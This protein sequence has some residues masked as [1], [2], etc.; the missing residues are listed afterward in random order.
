MTYPVPYLI[1]VALL[2][3]CALIVAAPSASGRTRLLSTVVAVASFFLFFAFRGFIMSDWIVYYPYFVHCSWSDIYTYTIGSV[4]AFEPGYTILNL[5]CR[6]VFD[7]YFFFQFVVCLIDTVLLLRFLRQR[8][9]NIPLALTLFVV[10]SGLSII[11]NL[12]RNF[13]AILLFLNAL[14]YLEERRPLPYFLMC[15]LAATFH[16]TALVYMPLYFILHRSFSKWIYLGVFIACNV[17]FLGKIS[18][19]MALVSYS[20]LDEQMSEKVRVYT[21]LFSNASVLSIGY[22][23]RLATGLLVFCYYDRLREINPRNSVIINALLLYFMAF[24]LLSE[25]ETL[26]QRSGYLFVFSYWVIWIDLMKCFAITN[27]RK[28]FVSFVMF[29]CLL[30]TWSMTQLPDMQYDNV[31]TGMKSYQERLVIHN[32]TTND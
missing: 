1:L 10:F 22:L 18:L 28:L 25:F 20:G 14:P 26:S 2:E 3:V 24:F 23:E 11:C 15:L 29:Y 12:M 4:V 5:V 27:N 32:K 31:L 21:E 7:D 6:S 9:D 19:V 13:I 30:K 8:V 16:M 17:V